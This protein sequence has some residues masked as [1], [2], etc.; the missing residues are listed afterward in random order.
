[1]GR[2]WRAR[3]TRKC[4]CFAGGEVRPVDRKV[5]SEGGGGLDAGREDEKC[6]PCLRSGVKMEGEWQW[7]GG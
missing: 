4:R 6:Q 5:E 3:F 1:M 2:G 7:R